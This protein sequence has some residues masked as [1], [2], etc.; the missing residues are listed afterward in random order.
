MSGAAWH[1]TDLVER[2]LVAVER[3]RLLA[4]SE[5]V[6]GA[7]FLPPSD[8]SALDADETG[9]RETNPVTGHSEEVFIS[10]WPAQI[11][12]V[13]SLFVLFYSFRTRLLGREISLSR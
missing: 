7:V 11:C 3:H 9:Y 10:T 5:S 13:L 1:G 4:A 8:S 2:R 6:S 12:F